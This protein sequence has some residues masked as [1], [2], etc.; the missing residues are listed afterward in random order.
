MPG[1]RRHARFKSEFLADYWSRHGVSRHARVLGHARTLAKWGSS[2]TAL[3]LGHEQQC[4]KRAGE[5]WLGIDSRRALP[6]SPRS[7]LAHMAPA[8]G[9]HCDAVVF[10]DTFT[11][12]Y[13]PEIGMACSTCCARRRACGTGVSSVLWAPA[14]LQGP[15]R[16][17]ATL[18]ERNAAALHPHAVAGRKI[19]F[20][21]PSCLSAMRED[22]PSLLRGDLR[23][24]A[25]AV[26]AA[27]VLFEEY[28]ETVVKKLRSSR[29]R[30]KFCCTATVPEVDGTAGA[31]Q[32]AARQHP[33][34]RRCRSRCRVLRHGGVVGYAP[35][36]ST[37]PG[38]R[39]AEAAPA[40]R[41]RKPGTVVVA[42]GTSCRH[43]C[44]I[45]RRARRPSRRAPRSLLDIVDV[46]KRM[47]LAYLSLG[48][49]V[50]AI[51]V[52]CFTELNVGI[53]S[54]GLR[55]DCRRLLRRHDAHQVIAGFPVALFLTLAA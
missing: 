10:N 40:V 51:L 11:N 26:A 23:K 1:R 39:R 9:A 35:R 49:L 29:D 19:V 34:R 41:N 48:A 6:R 31:R 38:D 24:K 20:C 43:R 2:S 30:Q 13:E 28:A 12:Y 54:P 37:S 27:C 7:R 46:R 32:V 25:E 15:A 14:D 16:G 18:A 21:E 47:N 44:T 5:K 33:G 36:I 45:S 4:G 8:S 53:L 22:A 55:V 17:S 3:Q 50:I 52:S 42:A